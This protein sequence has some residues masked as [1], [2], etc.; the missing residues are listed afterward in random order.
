MQR[1]CRGSHL[2]T[3]D[4]P[5]ELVSSGLPLQQQEQSSA[6]LQ[7]SPGLTVP[8]G[9]RQPEAMSN[10]SSET[11]K[12][13]LTSRMSMCFITIRM[14]KDILPFQRRKSKVQNIKFME[15][16]RKLKMLSQCTQIR[17]NLAVR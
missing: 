5:T 12:L 9:E 6:H 14:K 17:W 13:N 15:E 10:D 4:C 11:L 7:P 1:G 8:Y 16:K 2:F 3:A